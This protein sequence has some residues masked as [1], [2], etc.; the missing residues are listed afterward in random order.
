MDGLS[1]PDLPAGVTPRPFAGDADVPAVVSVLE[2]CW[3]ADGV[4]MTATPNTVIRL[5]A[6]RHGF[7]PARQALLVTDER[8]RVV[9]FARHLVERLRNGSEVCG[10]HFAVIPTWRERGV[11]RA[12]LDWNE[13]RLRELAAARI[14]E[15]G[16][17]DD[18]G[19][20]KL[21]W[22]AA[23]HVGE[24]ALIARLTAAGYAPVHQDLDMLRPTMDAIEPVALPDGFTL[25]PVTMDQFLT[26]YLAYKSFFADAFD[27]TPA[28]DPDYLRWIGRRCFQDLSL[29]HVAWSGEHVAGMT[30]CAISAEE[31]ARFGRA[32]GLVEHV[33]VVAGYRGQGLAGALLARA[34]AT[35][36]ER[37][38]R[39]ASLVVDAR[40]KYGAIHLYE[41]AGFVANGLATTYAKPLT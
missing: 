12:L 16:A 29:C 38:M 4:E 15:A 20:R 35:L 19:S 36:R 3:R 5:F 34:L 26:L 8:G 41:R 18:M 28:S 31:N 25:R 40:N 23:L 14:S 24:A 32:R 9:A 1:Q 6:P 2:E 13:G 33:G 22:L 39:E 10:H 27:A 37:G 30:L 7:D 17:A 21:S 11:E